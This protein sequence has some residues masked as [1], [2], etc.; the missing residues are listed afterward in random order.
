M[1]LKGLAVCKRNSEYVLNEG[2]VA[3]IEE[4]GEMTAKDV[5]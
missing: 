2:E 3:G 4:A 1:G 5:C